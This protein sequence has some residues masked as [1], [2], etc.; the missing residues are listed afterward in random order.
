[1]SSFFDKPHPHLI[2]FALLEVSKAKDGNNHEK[3]ALP[4]LNIRIS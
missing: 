1:M 4:Q 2:L 3:A